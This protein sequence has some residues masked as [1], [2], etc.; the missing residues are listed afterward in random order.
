MYDMLLTPMPK[1]IKTVSDF[2]RQTKPTFEEISQADSPVLVLNRNRQVGVFL[3]PKLYQ[4][5][6][7][8]YED[9]F[10][11]LELEEAT[12]KTDLSFRPLH[13]VIQDIKTK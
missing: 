11:G 9:Y 12:K 13:K 6:M 2:Q 4:K 7:D 8:I 3:N 10:D 5:L 1:I